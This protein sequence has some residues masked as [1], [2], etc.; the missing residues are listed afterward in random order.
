MYENRTLKFLDLSTLINLT[1]IYWHFCNKTCIETIL[2]PNG[3]IEIENYF[4]NDN[5]ALKV[6]D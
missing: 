2:F 4:I 5:T 1:C 3:L 6:L